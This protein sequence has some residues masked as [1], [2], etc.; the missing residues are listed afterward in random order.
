[1]LTATLRNVGGAVMMTIP[2]PLLKGL[3]LSA[4]TKV[5]LSLEDGRLVIEPRP[6]PKYTLA[7]LL[8]Q[9]DASIPM[10]EEE[11]AWQEM[12]PVGNE[13]W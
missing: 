2:K 6:K 9:C 4:N 10:N 11:L 5:R 12:K 13:V 1:M 3:G 7:A 8:E